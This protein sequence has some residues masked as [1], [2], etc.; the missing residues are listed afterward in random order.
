MFA[1][2]L[3]PAIQENKDADS[4]RINREILIHRHHWFALCK[5]VVNIVKL[6]G[7]FDEAE[8][9]ALTWPGQERLSAQAYGRGAGLRP[10]R[11]PGLGLPVAASPPRR[12]CLCS[13]GPTPACRQTREI[14]LG[15][16]FRA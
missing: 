4:W 16:I 15:R 2:R 9:G 11:R 10:I 14:E 12:V 5:R 6:V 8:P 1:D 7:P 13:S 3:L